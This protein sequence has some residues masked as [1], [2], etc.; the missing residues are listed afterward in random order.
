MKGERKMNEEERGE[1]EEYTYT[2]IRIRTKR[3]LTLYIPETSRSLIDN[4][5]TVL[6][7]EGK[8]ISNF[9]VE[10]LESYYRLHEPGNPQ[11]RLDTILKL[12]KAYHAPC[13]VCG[14]KNCMR[15]SVAVGLFIPNKTEYA[16]CKKH[17]DEA[18]ENP[19]L[20]KILVK[21]KRGV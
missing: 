17:Y 7:R 4:A 20:W 6:K 15:D 12:G 14:F 8:S 21:P 19:S 13:R 16:L 9:L 5:R 2:Y 11:Q 10:Q 1:S 18:S 3:K